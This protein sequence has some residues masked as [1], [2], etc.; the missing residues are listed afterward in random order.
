M[1]EDEVQPAVVVV[2]EKPK[3]EPLRMSDIHARVAEAR[4]KAPQA[5]INTS[6][7]KAQMAG[8]VA[9]LDTIASRITALEDA[10]KE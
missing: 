7:V 3:G 9:R 2:T 6:D 8:I 10:G 4:K 5:A 1:A